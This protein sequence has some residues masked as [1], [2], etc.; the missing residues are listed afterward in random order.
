M[1]ICF[2]EWDHAH[3]FM[4][5]YEQTLK[6]ENIH[7]NIM[8]LLLNLFLHK[9]HAMATWNHAYGGIQATVLTA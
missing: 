2:S 8:P 1:S 5:T 6:L 4:F 7:V 3:C 9:D